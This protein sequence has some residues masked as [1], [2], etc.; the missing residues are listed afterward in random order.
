MQ[1]YSVQP[2]DRIFEKGYDFLSVDTVR[3]SKQS[4]TGVLKTA[5]KRA[6]QNTAEATGN[7][8]GNKVADKIT[9]VSKTAPKNNLEA[10]E[11]KILRE[12]YVSPKLR[13]KIIDDLR[14]KKES[15]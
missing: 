7:L 3:N 6:I 13:H 5:S 9:R 15:Y 2:S 1:C 10:N 4:A 12:R 8:I 14:L 11:K